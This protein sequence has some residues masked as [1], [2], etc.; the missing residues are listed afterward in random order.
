MSWNR[1]KFYSKYDGA[2][3][4]NLKRA[5]KILIDFDEKKKC[6]INDVIEFYQIKLYIDNEVFLPQWTSEELENCKSVS[7][8]MWSFIVRFWQNMN[9]SNFV[10]LFE[11]LECWTVQDSFWELTANLS[12]YKQISNVSFGSFLA[13]H[14]V[15]VRAILYQEKI[16]NYFAKELCEFLLSYAET[17]ELLLA[18]YVE[19]HD[20]EWRSFYF[21]KSLSLKDKED[22]ISRYLDSDDPNP[23]YVSL[24]LNSRKLEQLDF[25]V[26]TR[27]KA[28]NVEDRLS[29]EIFNQGPVRK[30]EVHVTF[31]DD[32]DTPIKHFVRDNIEH[33]SYCTKNIFKINHPYSFLSLFTNLFGYLDEQRCISLVKNQSELDI[34]EILL[35]SSRFEYNPGEEFI[36][37]D[38]LS[39]SQMC[40]FDQELFK[41]EGINTEF[42]IHYYIAKHIENQFG[43][44]G[45]RFNLPTVGVSYLEKIRM[46]LAE[47]DSFMR[48]FKLYREEGEID[49]ELFKMST[50]PYA[51]SQ[52]PS[53]VDNK[54]CYMKSG[55][56]SAV[57][58][59]IFSDQSILLY[60][61]LFKDK[62]YS[63]F[64]DLILMEDVPY[65][66]FHAY[67]KTGIDHLIKGRYLYIDDKGF[68]RFSNENQIFI[69]KQLFQKGVLNYWHYGIEFRETIDDMISENSVYVENTLFNKLECDYLNYYL[70]DREFTDGLKLRNNYTH[71]TNSDSES[72]IE[73]MY[74]ILL[75]IIVLTLLKVDDDLLLKKNQN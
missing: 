66:S 27:N 34:I 69:L 42:L 45:F 44:S 52:I 51:F 9:S 35:M 41:R 18:Q 16:V 29:Q 43:L 46:L 39:Y 63:S 68:V 3:F 33:Y 64:C 50:E 11:S 17:A 2:G 6:N 49:F 55:P 1:I 37:K 26:K 75:R 30:I 13:N 5:E 20:R 36:R 19:K 22:V 8:K 15:N 38:F 61:E 72:E 31:S 21:P 23:N 70:N 58:R 73:K 60:V 48:Q 25:S 14:K 10:E 32:Q 71:G 65:E 53:F 57:V 59:L 67:Q 74:Y 24:V 62:Q 4:S 7:K 47:F 28:R 12:V 54:Y 56:I 40:F